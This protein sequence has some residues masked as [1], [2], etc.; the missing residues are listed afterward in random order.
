M[1]DGIMSF[2]SWRI[3]LP[4]PLPV[5]QLASLLWRPACI[6]C[7][8]VVHSVSAQPAADHPI[9]GTW[10]FSV[11]GGACAE[12]YDFRE[13]GILVTSS[14]KARSERVFEISASPDASGFYT[15]VDKIVSENGKPDCFGQ[16]TVAGVSAL[17][18]IRFSPSQDRF[19]ACETESP[20]N[21]IGPLH[22]IRRNR[23]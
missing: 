3:H 1:D 17:V 6:A 5:K 14:G 13:N 12:S 16:P 21:C 15:L 23:I 8:L 11:A 22:R 2:R 18:Y 7:F 19:V 9:L 20:D 4:F 10:T